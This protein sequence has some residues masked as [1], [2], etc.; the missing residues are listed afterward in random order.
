MSGCVFPLLTKAGAKPS[1]IC[2]KSVVAQKRES[3]LLK[4]PFGPLCDYFRLL[5][6]LD[7]HGL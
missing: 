5:N 4:I 2:T 1:E 7:V 3:K 6:G